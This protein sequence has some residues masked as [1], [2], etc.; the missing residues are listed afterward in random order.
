M[1]IGHNFGTADLSAGNVKNT[2]K[3]ISALEMFN[4]KRVAGEPDLVAIVARDIATTYGDVASAMFL[5]DSEISSVKELNPVSQR[6]IINKWFTSSLLIYRSHTDNKDVAE[7]MMHV[8]NDGTVDQWFEHLRD[9]VILFFKKN[10]VL[11]IA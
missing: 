5:N 9:V 7:I 11:G 8:I 10:N 2:E 6:I 1:A 3:K 4:T